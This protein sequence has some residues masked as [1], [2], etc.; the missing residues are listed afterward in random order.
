MTPSRLR[1]PATVAAALLTAVALTAC[2]GERTVPAVGSTAAAAPATATSAAG[3]SPSTSAVRPSAPAASPS[4]A[5]ARP[6][7]PTKRP[8]P[9]VATLRKALASSDADGLDTAGSTVVRVPG[10]SGRDIRYRVTTKLEF[11]DV[12]VDVYLA[13]DA[14]P[15]VCT[16]GD[17]GCVVETWASAP[18]SVSWKAPDTGVDDITSKVE[19]RL[20]YSVPGETPWAA[21]VVATG[22]ARDG[23][24]GQEAMRTLGFDLAAALAPADAIPPS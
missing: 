14:I 5:A 22:P 21:R 17:A 10:T 9:R 3:G 20:S 19:V 24:P 4:A 13:R 12:T 6:A 23:F 18:N 16:E 2:G 7:Q 15:T 11:A 8:D 1:P